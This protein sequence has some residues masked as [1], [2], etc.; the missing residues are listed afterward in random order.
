MCGRTTAPCVVNDFLLRNGAHFFSN[1][2]GKP[3]FRKLP[4][5][6][7]ARCRC[8]LRQFRRLTALGDF[9]MRGP[10]KRAK[11]LFSHDFWSEVTQNA[12]IKSEKCC[13]RVLE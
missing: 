9:L 13:Y 3:F 12:R 8:G 2:D 4:A 6:R 5:P 11:G 1:C 7:R 10:A